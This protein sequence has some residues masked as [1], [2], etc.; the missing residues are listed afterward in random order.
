[1]FA[2]LYIFWSDKPFW[3]NEIIH[4]FQVLLTA[5]KFLCYAPYMILKHV[6]FS[7]RSI[8]YGLNHIWSKCLDWY[9]P[10]PVH[11][12]F[13]YCLYA[14]TPLDNSFN[15]SATYVSQITSTTLMS[16]QKKPWH[17][18]GSDWKYWIKIV[19]SFTTEYHRK[20]CKKTR[21]FSK[22]IPCIWMLL[23]YFKLSAIF[24]INSQIFLCSNGINVMIYHMVQ[25]IVRSTECRVSCV[26]I[27][28][29]KRDVYMA[30]A[31]VIYVFDKRY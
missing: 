19:K 22:K 17:R 21:I 31:S 9:P 25:K 20:Y 12:T 13:V 6:T 23:L 29:E 18:I 27:K 30:R 2:R 16:L 5:V 8:C 4:V 11:K 28:E 26:C 15:Q 24:F 10:Q 1:M 7:N 14:V 3:F